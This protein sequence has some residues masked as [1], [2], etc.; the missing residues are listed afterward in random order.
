MFIMYLSIQLFL[1]LKV[2]GIFVS[3]KQRL[4]YGGDE[5]NFYQ[6]FE[7]KIME[8]GTKLNNLKV[9]RVLR[10]SFMISFPLIIFGSIM[11]V[12]ANLPFLDKILSPETLNSLKT[13][14]GPASMT[15][16]SITT[17]FVTLGIGYYFSKEEGVDPIFGAAISLVS[18]LLLT[19]TADGGDL[20]SVLQIDRL[21][22]KGMFIGMIAAFL[23]AYMYTFFVKKN[24]TIK[25][26]D[27]VPPAVSKSFAAL[28]PAV[29]TLSTF[30][31]INIIFTFT[32]W[33]NPH[34]FI[35]EIIQ[36]PLTKLGSG[37]AATVVAIFAVQI[38]WF[39]GLHG[40]IIVNSVMDPI[41]NTLS[42]ENLNAFQ[43]GAEMPNIIT[44]QFIETFTVGLG[45]T[46]MTLIV[47]LAILIFMKSRQLKE[48][49]R[50]AAPAGLF[51]VNEPVIFGLP[52]VLNPI[53]AIP[54]II[55]PVVATLVAY[56]AMA[57]GLV[58]ATTGVAVPWT[59]PVLISG[60]LATNS[61]AGSILQLVQMAIV[62]VIWFPFLMAL[63]KR[64]CDLEKE[65]KSA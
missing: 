50:L 6:K 35:Y 58:P 16:M 54:W 43:A 18:F 52:I 4:Q 34:D 42:L 1:L 31:V 3:S 12:I 32:P 40:Q 14:L 22:A 56:F 65:E 23:S 7:G 45:G 48:I 59:T 33:G 2:F 27:T 24:W 10:D 5:M 37:I 13:F 64:N 36:T 15:T 61:I 25:M 19:P 26:P 21:G 11:L 28:I 46:G 8:F 51:N 20:G 29:F 17:I 47:I 41:W 62:L 63:D 39:F 30:L 44:K 38:L 57:S 49:A 55:A 9:L 60:F 53:I